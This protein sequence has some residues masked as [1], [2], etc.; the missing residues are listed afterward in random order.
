MSDK[1]KARPIHPAAKRARSRNG[2]R[3]AA[4]PGAQL[5]KACLLAFLL[6]AGSC[7]GLLAL[8]ALLLTHT[9][10]PLALVRP[11]AGLAAAAGAAVTGGVLAR[12]MGRGML[13]CGLGSGLFYAVCQMA[14][15]FLGNGGLSLAG[16][17]LMLPVALVLGG[18]LGGS[19][20]A[21]RSV[22]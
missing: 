22:R 17:D 14:A 2:R 8:F 4:G 6:G 12:R 16:P 7:V 18:L 13:L 10:L 3:P 1:V 9:P 19:F 20:A 15:A 11:L 5:V 21:L